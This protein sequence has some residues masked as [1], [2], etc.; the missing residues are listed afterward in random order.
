[1]AAGGEEKKGKDKDP[2]HVRRAKRLVN[3]VLSDLLDPNLYF[4]RLSFLESGKDAIDIKEG[5]KLGKRVGFQAYKL[6]NVSEK[7]YTRSSMVKNMYA[8]ATEGRVRAK[9]SDNLQHLK[10]SLTD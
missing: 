10:A 5:L 6:P 8:S 9:Y 2:F 4:S 3:G 1:M 7:F